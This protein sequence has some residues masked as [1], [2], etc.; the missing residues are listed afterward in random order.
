M[1]EKV[2]KVMGQ[3]PEPA[4]Q[5][6]DC[7]MVLKASEKRA[8]HQSNPKKDTR[9]SLHYLCDEFLGKRA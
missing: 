5:V 3:F 9:C 7:V 1:H 2:F 6:V 8:Y 4:L